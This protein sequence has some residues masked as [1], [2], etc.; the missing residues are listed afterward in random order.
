MLDVMIE[1]RVLEVD[2]APLTIGQPAVVEDLQEDVED[3]GRGLLDLVEQ[4]D[5]ERT[6]ADRLGQLA[7]LL[8]ADVARRRADQPRDG[9]L[10]AVLRHIDTH[11]RPLVV[12]QVTGEGPREFGLAD[13]GRPEEDERTDRPVRIREAGTRPDDGLRDRRDRFVLADDA[14]VQ[15]LVEA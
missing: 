4:H 8:V 7:A 9:M 11:H 13:A 2:G 1:D 3:V 5:G 10:L 15:F 14:L 12:E 6:A